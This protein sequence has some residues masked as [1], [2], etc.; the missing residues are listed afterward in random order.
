MSLSFKE[1]AEIIKIIDAS[2]CEELSLELEG[3]RLSV[4]RASA[5][6]TIT[7]RQEDIPRAPDISSSSSAVLSTQA[8]ASRTIEYDDN[9]SLSFAFVGADETL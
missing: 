8:T 3:I 2:E 5:S 9:W 4:R 7:A 1:V 6:G